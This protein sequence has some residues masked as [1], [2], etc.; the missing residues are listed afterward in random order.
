MSLL[1]LYLLL[2]KATLL[3]FSGLSSLPIVHR[4]FVLE[5][6]LI[7][8]RQLNT[9]VAMA[10]ATPGPLGLYLVCVGY[11]V[12][13]YP[14]AA[15][16][17]LAMITPAFL[18]VPLLRFAAAR[19]ADHRFERAIRSLTLAAA[20]LLLSALLPLAKDAVTGWGTAAVATASFLLLA[21]TRVDTIW[22]VAA[23]MLLGVLPVW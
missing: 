4:D 15:A 16:A 10:R 20:G 22:V 7:T 8:D 19:A 14:G 18:I 1:V 11:F 2:L 6:R 5:R 9:S 3:S 21:F 13:G 23:A 12:A 17:F